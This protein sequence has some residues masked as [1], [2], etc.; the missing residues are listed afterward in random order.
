MAQEYTPDILEQARCIIEDAALAEGVAAE[1]QHITDFAY[2]RDPET[3]VLQETKNIA[4]RAPDGVDLSTEAKHP[5]EQVQ[6]AIIAAQLSMA[7]ASL[8]RVI[9]EQPR[10]QIEFPSIDPKLQT[11]LLSHLVKRPP[12]DSTEV[13]RAQLTTPFSNQKPKMLLDNLPIP[14][15]AKKYLPKE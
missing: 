15:S 6:D 7:L 11:E 14:D 3:A 9:M 10:R 5:L 4:E 8:A 2:M 1:A 12:T 13:L